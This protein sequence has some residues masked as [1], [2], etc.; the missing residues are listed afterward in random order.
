[1]TSINGTLVQGG[2]AAL[3]GDRSNLISFSSRLRGGRALAQ[4]VWSIY[5]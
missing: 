4:D 3:N 5:K 2:K 1:M